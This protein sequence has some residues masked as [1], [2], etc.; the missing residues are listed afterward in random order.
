MI[1]LLHLMIIEKISL[2]NIRNLPL[3]SSFFLFQRVVLFSLDYDC[4]Q[5]SK[6]DIG[7]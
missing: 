7:H 2:Q 6:D 4:N 1:I 5:K 3:W